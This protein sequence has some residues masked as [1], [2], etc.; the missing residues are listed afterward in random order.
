MT[1]LWRA[2]AA[3]FLAALGAAVALLIHIPFVD[4]RSR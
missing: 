2:F 3:G 4:R 1:K